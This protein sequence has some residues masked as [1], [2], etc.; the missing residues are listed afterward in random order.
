MYLTSVLGVPP[1]RMQQSLHPSVYGLLQLLQERTLDV[2]APDHVQGLCQSVLNTGW[3][4][5]C[6][7]D[8]R[9]PLMQL[10]FKA[11]PD[12]LNRVHIW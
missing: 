5:R 11:L 4:S 10:L 6:A 2:L 1:L 8:T 3:A 9:E 7:G 12:M